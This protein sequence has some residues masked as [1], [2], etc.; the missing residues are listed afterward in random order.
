MNMQGTLTIRNKGVEALLASLPDEENGPLEPLRSWTVGLL[1][2]AS[3]FD[4]RRRC[5]GMFS[6]GRLQKRDAEA[7]LQNALAAN[8]QGGAA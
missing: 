5:S 4:V 6:P 8:K 1:D 7:A 2:D 3:R